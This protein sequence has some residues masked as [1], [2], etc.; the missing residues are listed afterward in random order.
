MKQQVYSLTARSIPRQ[1]R[2]ELKQ[3]NEDLFK[4]ASPE[5]NSTENGTNIVLV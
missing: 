5:V 1:F 2:Q 4:V 3:Q